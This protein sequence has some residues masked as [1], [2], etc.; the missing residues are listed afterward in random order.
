MPDR[1]IGVGGVGTPRLEGGLIEP[2]RQ[3]IDQ[4]DIAG[5]LGMFLL[6]NAAGDEDA[7]MADRFMHG[8]D[9]GLPI[10]PDLVDVG[11]EVEDPVQ[12]LLRWSDVVA[13]GAEHHDRRADIAQVDRCAVGHLDAAGGEVIADEE[14]IDD[15][16]NLLGI[17]IDVAAPPALEIEIAIGFGV[18]L[19]KDI[20]LLRP[21]RVRWILALEILHEPRAVELA[22]A[23]VARKRGQ[24]TSAEQTARIAHRVFAMHTRPVSER[25][26]GDDQ[27]AE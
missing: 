26:A 14:L 18:D 13:L 27:G 20:V 1:K 17:Q 8:V 3:H 2:G 19:G 6:G 25:S 22:A 5:E 4:V 10:G 7:E 15:E 9:N 11:I 16:L 24:P 12:R 21:Q 23:E